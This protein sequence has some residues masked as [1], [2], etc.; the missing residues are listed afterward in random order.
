MGRELVGRWWLTRAC[1]WLA[2]SLILAPSASH[3]FDDTDTHPRI[4]ERSVSASSLDNSL[5]ADLGIPEGVKKLLVPGEG[6]PLSIVDWLKSGARLEDSPACRARNHFHNPLRP[7]DSSGVSDFPFLLSSFCFA[8]SP[9]K[10]TVSNVTWG[11]RFTAP[12]TKGS[13]VGNPFDW[14]AARAAFFNGLT[15]PDPAQ[16]EAA[17]A[18]TFLSL[19]HVLH[20]IQDLGV[21][22][23]VRNDFPWHRRGV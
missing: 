6:R 5:K 22:G 13:P 14:D 21:P 16:R 1:L 17:L 11:T 4:T 18:Q 3:S 10:Q 12:T 2:A 23:H 8:S 20:P 15:L 7:F 19:G 9:F